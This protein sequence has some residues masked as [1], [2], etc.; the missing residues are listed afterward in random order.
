LCYDPLRFISRFHDLSFR[1][2]Q[3]ILIYIYICIYNMIMRNKERGTG[4]RK[5]GKAML[6]KKLDYMVPIVMFVDLTC[7]IFCFF[8]ENY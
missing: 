6:G 1:K 5:R 3:H 8:F 2:Q 4:R 7:K